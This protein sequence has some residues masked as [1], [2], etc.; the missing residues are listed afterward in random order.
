PDKIKA[1]ELSAFDDVMFNPNS[2]PQLQRLL[3]EVMG[4][5][6][7]DLTDTK[8]PATGGDTLEKLINHATNP[9]HKAV[10]RALIEYSGAVKILNT[11]IPAFEEA[12]D[13]GDGVIWLHG[14]FNL[15]GTVSGRLSSSDP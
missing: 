11:F 10:I 4:L 14:N 12:L 13:K 6:E 3:Y 2:G 8:L 9:D 1:K 5:P 7:I 15:G